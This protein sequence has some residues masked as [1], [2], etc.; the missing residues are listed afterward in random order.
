MAKINL[1]AR[2]QARYGIKVS[3]RPYQLQAAARGMGMDNIALLMDP[4]LGKTRI[5]IAISGGRFLLQEMDKWIVVAP[6][7]AKD[8]W[9][10]ELEATLAVPH[11][12]T[13]VEG[14]AEERKLL[15]K[16]WKT[17]PG[18]LNILVL[19]HE[20]TWRL[21]K[22]LYKSDPDK[23]TV[24]ESQKIANHATNQSKCCHILARRARFHTIL[25]GTFLPK[26]TAA[27]SQ[28]KFLDPKVFG[29][30]WQRNKR[31]PDSPDGF[32]DRY[33]RTWGYGGH[34][35]KTFKNLDD[36]QEK[37]ASRAFQLTRA[38][39][40]GFPEEFYEDRYCDLGQEAAGHYKRMLE[41]LK[42]VVN[43]REVTA[44][45]VLT[46]TLRMQQITAGFLPVK[47]PNDEQATNVE[48]GGDKARLLRGVLEEYPLETPLVIFVRF[49]YELA[50]VKKMCFD[51]G[52]PASFIA[53]GQKPGDRDAAKHAFQTHKTVNTCVVQIRAGGIAID[54]SRAD[55]SIFFHV[56]Q[57]V[58]DWDQA[59]ARI[60]AAGDGR[61]VILRLLARGTVDEDAR[62]NLVERGELSNLILGRYKC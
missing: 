57:S 59:R 47:E 38:E 6:A 54:L 62:D 51:L 2:Y 37:I 33:V 53:G 7:V 58:T 22:F 14:K 17:K 20:A 31:R 29:T 13:L 24:D 26:P 8:V 52:R 32:L 48:I 11:E 5:D 12:V 35:P 21:K 45:I 41:E 36:M 16:G 43:Q 19:N 23:V 44:K 60:I 28:Y 61:K 42:T 49:K 27:F 39:A 56:P 46:Q 18:V 10:M 1:R 50:R 30:L 34:K 25:T 40:G 3:M 15:I 4:R 9:R 55:T